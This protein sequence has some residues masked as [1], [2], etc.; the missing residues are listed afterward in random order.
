MFRPECKRALTQTLGWLG[1]GRGPGGDLQTPPNLKAS[2]RARW[3]VSS[4]VGTAQLTPVGRG[5]SPTD[6]R[7]PPR[8]WAEGWY[9]ESPVGRHASLSPPRCGAGGKPPEGGVTGQTAEPG[10][11][12]RPEGVA[13]RTCADRGQ[14]QVLA[15]VQ[16][17]GPQPRWRRRRGGVQTVT[18]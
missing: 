16:V 1:D 6:L 18:C 4:A 8:R 5:A 15:E 9:R 13:S 11:P 2:R 7:R 12:H 3:P 17:G 14:S 10:V